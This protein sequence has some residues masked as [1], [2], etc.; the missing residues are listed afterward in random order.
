[1]LG[2]AV[3]AAVAGASGIAFL[4]VGWSGDT[5]RV[6]LVVFAS[7]IVAFFACGSASIFTAARDTYANTPRSERD[8]SQH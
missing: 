3:A 1:M 7:A 8:P 5:R 2:M 6:V 4:T